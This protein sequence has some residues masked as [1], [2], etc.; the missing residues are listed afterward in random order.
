MKLDAGRYFHCSGKKSGGV[1][2]ESR[3]SL[4]A[5][6]SSSVGKQLALEEAALNLVGRSLGVGFA[7]RHH[8]FSWEK[9]LVRV[10]PNMQ[11]QWTFPWRKTLQRPT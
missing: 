2:A 4:E 5:R 9:S 6:P 1:K 3:G 7:V 11:H 10:E 8:D